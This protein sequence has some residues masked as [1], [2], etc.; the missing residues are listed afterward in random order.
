MINK[1]K[2][3]EEIGFNKLLMTIS[4]AISVSLIGWLFNN[5]DGHISLRFLI[6]FFTLTI[7]LYFTNFFIINTKN[8]I[9]ELC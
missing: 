8:K 7:S 4:S 1:D 9:E 2:L 5:F 3:K 6:V